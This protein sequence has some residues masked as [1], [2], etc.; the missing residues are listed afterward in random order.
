M[1]GLGSGHVREDDGCGRVSSSGSHWAVVRLNVLEEPHI[2]AT[3]R[4]RSAGFEPPNGTTYLTRET[5]VRVL[6]PKTSSSS[7]AY[8]LI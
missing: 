1:P 4:L 5:E 8:L 6:H 3:S 7:L 2:G